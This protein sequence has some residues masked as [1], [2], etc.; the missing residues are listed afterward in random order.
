M[1]AKRALQLEDKES[2]GDKAT[3]MKMPAL[4]RTFS[5]YTGTRVMSP[6]PGT[7]GNYQARRKT[8]SAHKT[9]AAQQDKLEKLRSK[10][11]KSVQ[12]ILKARQDLESHLPL[13]GS[14]ELRRLFPR[15]PGDLLTELEKHREL[16][17]KV[18]LSFAMDMVDRQSRFTGFPPTGNSHEFLKSLLR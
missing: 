1:S 11:K 15:R 14:S 7:K 8:S 17:A 3:P 6:A 5:P 2:V 10:V 12:S 13:E 9:Q 16:V 4:E 18:E